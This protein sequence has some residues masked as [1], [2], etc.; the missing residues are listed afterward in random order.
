MS[1]GRLAVQ[2]FAADGTT[3][4]DDGHVVVINNQVDQTT[5]TVQLKADAIRDTRG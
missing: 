1:R 4:I 2:A 3:V 5:G